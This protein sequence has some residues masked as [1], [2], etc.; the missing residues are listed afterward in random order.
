MHVNSQKVKNLS[1]IILVN[2][3]APISVSLAFGPHS[4]ASTENATVWGWLSG[5]SVFLTPM[6][7]PKMLNAKQG[8]S[9]HYFQ[10][11]G[12]TQAGMEPQSTVHKVS[13]LSL[14]HGL[15]YCAW[16]LE[17]GRDF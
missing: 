12:L 16:D 2:R 7:F 17:S 11:F 14:G 3:M 9:M 10:V 15:R 6:L 5:S 13:I 8:N 1:L 4:C